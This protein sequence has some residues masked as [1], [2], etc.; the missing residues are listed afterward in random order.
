MTNL[1]TLHAYL[2]LI[3]HYLGIPRWIDV[4]MWLLCLEDTSFWGWITT[5]PYLLPFETVDLYSYLMAI[6]LWFYNVELNVSFM[7]P[8]FSLRMQL[9]WSSVGENS[10]YHNLSKWRLKFIVSGRVV[11]KRQSFEFNPKLGL[12]R[13]YGLRNNPLLGPNLSVKF[14]KVVVGEKKGEKSVKTASEEFSW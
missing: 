4:L 3:K 7:S 5:L 13:N 8:S 6:Y 11:L 2:D 14:L 9:D 12:I 1:S 10:F